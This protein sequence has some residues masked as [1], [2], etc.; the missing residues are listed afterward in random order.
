MNGTRIDPRLRERRLRVRRQQGR[1]RLRRLIGLVLAMAL[2][3][4]VV[5]IA[6]S[7]L[8]DI[9]RVVVEGVS[10][11]RADEV[12]QVSGITLGDPLATA[13]IGAAEQR[14][15]ALPWVR[16]VDGSRRWP[17]TVGLVVVPR[18]AFALAVGPD[19]AG[20]VVDVDGVAI[21]VVDDTSRSTLPRVDVV[22]EGSLGTV[23]EEVLPVL[24]LI[25][26]VPEDLMVWIEV[27][28]TVRN[29]AEP[30]SFS[31]DLVGSATADL[32][33]EDDLPAKL[34]ALRAILGRVDRRCMATID[35]QVAEL[36]SV[37]RDPECEAQLP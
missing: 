8:L 20:I 6:R 18:E 7:E 12:R 31:L 32:G 23:Q 11:P 35:L 19:G 22:V 13:G 33:Y 30:P 25:A 16:S 17:S 3:A 28:S 5:L 37:R 4:L 26:V 9:D 21:E 36:P 29:D 1:R 34:E 10:G 24:A 27:F 15:T 2:V 14:V